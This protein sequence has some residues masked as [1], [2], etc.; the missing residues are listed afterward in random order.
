MPF[1]GGSFGT[2]INTVGPQLGFEKDEGQPIEGLKYDLVCA[3]LDRKQR[4]EL[5]KRQSSDK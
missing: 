1:L 4:G 2:T 3:I 5:A